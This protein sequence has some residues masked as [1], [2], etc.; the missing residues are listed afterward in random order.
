MISKIEFINLIKNKEVFDWKVFKNENKENLTVIY[1]WISENIIES[2]SIKNFRSIMHSL[3]KLNIIDINNY[4]KMTDSFYIHSLFL[5][6]EEFI[7][8]SGENAIDFTKMYSQAKYG[9]YK[10]IEYFANIL[11]EYMIVELQN[12]DS[13]WYIF[14]ENVKKSNEKIVLLTTGWRSAPSTANILF[15]NFSKKLNVWLALKNYPTIINVKL[16][17]LALP[18]ENY[19]SLSEMERISISKNR[20]HIIPE[21][22][23]FA[24]NNVHIIFGDDIF[25]TGSTADKLQLECIENGAKSFKSLYLAILNPLDSFLDPS[26]EEYL[27]KKFI[28]EDLNDDVANLLNYEYFTPVL[29]T[30][31][32]IFDKKNFIQLSGFLP[33]VKNTVWLNIYIS[34][35]N[36]DFHLEENCKPSIELLKK[37]LISTK[38]LNVEGIP[39]ISNK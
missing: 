39:L 36:N 12:K 7:Y 9:S 19:A 3:L 23:F 26:L 14:F 25:I 4:F 1:N 8:D 30:L 10:D 15:E 22:N 29:R 2:M 17:R 11:Y 31:R 18:C 35:L 28:T 5:N 37:Y 21:S 34:A 33:K 32:L 6:N 27:N 20:D 38:T 24:S 16:P 13:Q